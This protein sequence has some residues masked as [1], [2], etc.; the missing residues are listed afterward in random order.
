MN[1]LNFYVSNRKVFL[2]L[3]IST[4]FLN[5]CEEKFNHQD[6][7][8]FNAQLALN[9]SIESPEGLI[10]HYYQLSDEVESHKI[11]ITTELLGNA[12][13][14]ITLIHDY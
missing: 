13:Y 6:P 12:K 1:H 4:I 10:K 3:L 11:T 14:S 8:L 5:A 9:N 7:K 2:L